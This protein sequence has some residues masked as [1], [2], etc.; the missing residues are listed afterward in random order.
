[1]KKIKIGLTGIALL[2]GCISVFASRINTLTTVYTDGNGNSLSAMYVTEHCTGNVNFC[3]NEY[4]D[5]LFVA[6]W[7]QQ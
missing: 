2:V 7:L 6:T 4:R 3:S 5:G 1:M